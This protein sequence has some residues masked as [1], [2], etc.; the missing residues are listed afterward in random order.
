MLNFRSSTCLGLLVLLLAAGCVPATR[1]EEAQ[2]ALTAERSAHRQTLS[3]AYHLQRQLGDAHTAAQAQQKRLQEHEERLAATNLE[4]KLT[5]TARDN[6]LGTVE[7]LRGELARAGEHMRAFS[8]EKQDLVK[9]LTAATTRAE[10]SSEGSQLTTERANMVRDVALAFHDKLAAG[11]YELTFVDG[12]PILLVPLATVMTGNQLS[13]GGQE[14]ARK[15]S[16]FMALHSEARLGLSIA[17]PDAQGGA[18]MKQLREQLTARGLSEQHATF[19]EAAAAAA[20]GEQ[21]AA[22]SQLRIEFSRT[23]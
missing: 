8:Q 12:R 6:A 23:S 13:A 14:L 5:G 10:S 20:P 3:R 21:A 19:D 4:N 15:L 17:G 1:Y 2:T 11:S 22:A 18:R 9:A 16:E 7:Q